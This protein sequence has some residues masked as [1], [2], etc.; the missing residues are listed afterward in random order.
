MSD[1]TQ[2]IE[3]LDDN[4]MDHDYDGIKELD[5]NL[6]PWWLYMFYITILF[7]IGYILNYHILKKSPLQD[8]EYAISM[9]NAEEDVAKYLASKGDVINESNVVVLT[10]EAAINAGS[11]TFAKYCVACHL[12]KGQGSI[13]PN[14]TDAYWIHGNTINDLF[15]TITNGVPEKG[16][17]PWG[18]QLSP[19]QIQQVASFILTKL[20]GT[21][22]EGK[23]PEGEKME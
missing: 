2:I 6:P 22:V 1:E 13:G 12:E 23:E 17:I 9:K 14:L 18:T 15:R 4:L 5:N 10:D 7:G 20:A 19:E 21:N 3:G 16:M 8:E 11:E